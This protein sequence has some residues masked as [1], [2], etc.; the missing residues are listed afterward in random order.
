VG[1]G[2]PGQA[3]LLVDGHP[4]PLEIVAQQRV[5]ARVLGHLTDPREQPEVVERGFTARDPV[6]R[7]LPGLAH[8]SRRLGEGADR[9]RPVVRGHSAEVIAGDQRRLGAEAGRAERCDDTG[10][11]GADDYDVERLGWRGSHGLDHPE[12]RRGRH[13]PGRVRR[14]AAAWCD[15]AGMRAMTVLPGQNATVGVEEV[16]EDLTA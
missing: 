3:G 6:E 2:E 8:Q 9:N 16:P 4:G 15:D 1:V 5:P 14:D 10:R 7:E 11:S 13:H 12:R